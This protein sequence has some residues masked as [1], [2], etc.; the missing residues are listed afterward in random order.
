MQ[1]S[2]PL[3]RTPRQDRSRKVLM[4]RGGGG[5]RGAVALPCRIKTLRL[6]EGHAAGAARQG[7]PSG[8]GVIMQGR[9]QAGA[10]SGWGAIRPV[11]S[12]RGVL[13]VLL[14]EHMRGALNKSPLLPFALPWKAPRESRGAYRDLADVKMRPAV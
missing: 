6:V 2:R 12:S 14:C 7:P 5:G 4:R 3:P 11:R 8:W 10:P 13:R 1:A 9:H